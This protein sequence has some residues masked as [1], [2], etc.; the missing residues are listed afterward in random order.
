MKLLTKADHE[1][2]KK[3]YES[4]IS[5][6]KIAKDYSLSGYVT[7]T[8]KKLTQSTVSHVLHGTYPIYEQLQSKGRR[9]GQRIVKGEEHPRYGKARGLNSNT[10]SLEARGFVAEFPVE[11]N[12]KRSNSY[13][14]PIQ[15]MIAYVVSS[16]IPPRM[17]KKLMLC[18]VG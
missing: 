4:G 14:S 10:R 1:D 16:E 18:L 9:P 6:S 11:R 13:L 8:G 5:Q 15:D 12:N 2:I 17:K 3:F 7:N